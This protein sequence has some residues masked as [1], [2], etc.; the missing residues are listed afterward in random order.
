MALIYPSY[1]PA[2]RC[3]TSSCRHSCCVGW[4]ID[5]DTESLIK[6][7]GIQGSFGD[8][9][10]NSISYEGTPHFCLGGGERCPH[11]DENN[12]CRMILELGE[13]SLCRICAE[14]PRFYNCKGKRREVGLGLCCEAAAELILS[15]KEPVTLVGD[16]NSPGRRAFWYRHRRTCFAAV[17]NRERS[18]LERM[19]VLL[20]LCGGGELPGVGEAIPLLLSLECMDPA[21]HQALKAMAESSCGDPAGLDREGEQLLFYFLYRYMTGEVPKKKRRGVACFAILSTRVILSL[22]EHMAEGAPITLF[23]L[24]EAAGMYSRE[25]EYSEENRDLIIRSFGKRHKTKKFV[26]VQT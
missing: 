4:E 26:E 11:L 13:E 21:W 19:K 12:L 7:Q 23:H 24:V 1:Y 25:V 5:I 3:V 16:E 2:F 14:H 22:A 15:Y 10:R 9:L 17:Q 8:T 20:D 6:Y 18:L